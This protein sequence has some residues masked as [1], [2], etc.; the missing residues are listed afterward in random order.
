MSSPTLVSSSEK[1]LSPSSYSDSS[2]PSGV[3]AGNKESLVHPHGAEKDDG[4]RMIVTGDVGVKESGI[5]D[6]QMSWQ[7]T[8]V[9]L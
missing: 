5:S 3:G 9:L 8:A 6:R 7:R 4:G 2:P 1:K